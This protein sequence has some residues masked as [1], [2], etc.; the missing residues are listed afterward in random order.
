MSRFPLEVVEKPDVGGILDLYNVAVTTLYR[1]GSRVVPKECQS[2]PQ[3]QAKLQAHVG[4]SSDTYVLV[5]EKP[6]MEHDGRV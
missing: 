1:V 3:R 2:G 5:L 4:V 6:V